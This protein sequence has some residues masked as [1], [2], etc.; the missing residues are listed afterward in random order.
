MTEARVTIRAFSGEDEIKLARPGQ[1]H[2]NSCDEN[3]TFLCQGNDKLDCLL[4]CGLAGKYQVLNYLEK[5]RV[6][7][8]L[9]SS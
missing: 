9:D 3:L 6:Y 5:H 8:V 2:S 7:R 1:P 4:I